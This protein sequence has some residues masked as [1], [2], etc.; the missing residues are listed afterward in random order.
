MSEKM[1]PQIIGGKDVYLVNGTQTLGQPYGKYEIRFLLHRKC[2]TQVQIE[3]LNV[4]SKI[5]SYYM[6]M[7]KNTFLSLLVGKDFLNNT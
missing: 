3:D 7:Q 2:K 4:K 1:V 6:K 5:L